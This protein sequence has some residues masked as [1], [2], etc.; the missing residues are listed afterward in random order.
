MK[1]FKLE[2]NVPMETISEGKTDKPLE[3]LLY[4]LMPIFY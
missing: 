3:A 2:R 4:Q 1:T